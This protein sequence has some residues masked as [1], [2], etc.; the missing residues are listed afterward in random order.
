M[1]CTSKHCGLILVY[2][3]FVGVA[4][5]FALFTSA[6]FFSDGLD[7]DAN[8]VVATVALIGSFICFLTLI[9]IGCIHC[10]CQTDVIFVTPGMTDDAKAEY[11]GEARVQSGTPFLKV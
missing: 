6:V 7:E 10:C 8:M 11:I 3:V 1:F 5:F 4:F 9:T 2:A